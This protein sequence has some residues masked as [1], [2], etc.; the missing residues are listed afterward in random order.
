MHDAILI[1]RGIVERKENLTSPRVA[2]DGMITHTH[3]NTHTGRRG[4]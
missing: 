1:R 2:H 4:V 3:D